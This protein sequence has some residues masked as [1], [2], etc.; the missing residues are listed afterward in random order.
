MCLLSDALG[1]AVPGEAVLPQMK[2]WGVKYV[3]KPLEQV[4]IGLLHLMILFS[5]LYQ[6]DGCRG[7][8]TLDLHFFLSFAREASYAAEGQH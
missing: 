5:I 6:K 2:M 7:G 3:H 1:A 8:G 4:L